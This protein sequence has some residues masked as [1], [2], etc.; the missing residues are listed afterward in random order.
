METAGAARTARVAPAMIIVFSVVISG[1]FRVPRGRGI[2]PD[3]CEI[4]PARLN[5]PGGRAS[6]TVQPAE[7]LF[8]SQ[9]LQTARPGGSRDPSRLSARTAL[10]AGAIWTQLGSRLAPG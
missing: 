7:P 4:A 5:G 3:A 8:S 2:R 6:A 9:P 1:S 10:N